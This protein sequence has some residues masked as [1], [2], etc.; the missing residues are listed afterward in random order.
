MD[1][2]LADLL[3]EYGIKGT[4]YVPLQNWERVVIDRSDLRLLAQ[5][6]EIGGHTR[7]HISLT[8][9]SDIMLED[10]IRGCKL[11]LEDI[12]G[13]PVRT[14]CY[15]GG[16][17]NRRVRNV[18]INAGFLCARTTKEFV[19]NLMDDPW[20]M[21]TT[22]QAFPQRP[23]I[24][25]CHSLTFGDFRST[26]KFLLA[27]P[28]KDWVTLAM[29]LFD[30]VVARGGVWHL[31]GHSWELEE[32]GLWDELRRILEFVSHRIDVQYLTNGE[33]VKKSKTTLIAPSPS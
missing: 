6:A 33:L 16:D 27:D 1:L 25:F 28:R 4:F 31:W 19:T 2:R 29:T 26:G 30:N 10:E 24:R 23:F 9:L 14:F 7:N 20:R 5:Y 13:N 8:S 11:D 15:P 21:A 18:V 22:L 32:Y 12:L 17:Y 3:K